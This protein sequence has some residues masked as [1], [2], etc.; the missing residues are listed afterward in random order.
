MQPIKNIHM[1]NRSVLTY[2]T[3]TIQIFN[4]FLKIIKTKILFPTTD[5]VFI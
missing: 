4:L 3:L 1:D 5:K 2:I